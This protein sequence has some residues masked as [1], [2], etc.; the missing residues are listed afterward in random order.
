M[1]AIVD[2][3]LDENDN[4]VHDYNRDELVALLDRRLGERS[5]RSL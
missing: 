2:K 4:P 5:N 1:R 3:L